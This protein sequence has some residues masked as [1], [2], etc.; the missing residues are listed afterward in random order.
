MLFRSRADVDPALYRGPLHNGLLKQQSIE[1][2]TRNTDSRPWQA[3]ARAVFAGEQR[4][5]FEAEMV[6]KAERYGETYPID[7][8]FLTALAHMP[9]A[10]GCAL[11]FDRLVM[12][13]TGAPRVDSVIWTP[14]PVQGK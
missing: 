11:G 14:L 3:R 10:S 1:P 7:E 5:R 9:P 12:L 6:L 4:R 8:D 2:L 13:A